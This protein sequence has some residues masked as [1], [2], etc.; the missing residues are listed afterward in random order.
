MG[1]RPFIDTLR[2]VDGGFLLEEMA[3]TQRE[4]VQA[5]QHTNRRGTLTLTLTY[6][7]EGQGQLSIEAAVKAKA[8]TL[9]RGRSLFFVTPDAN[10]DRN[11]P[12]QQTLDMRVVEDERPNPLRVAG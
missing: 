3:E 10:L 1:A 11:D 2:Q 8:P 7:P 9:P 5:I 4:L 6:T 12:R